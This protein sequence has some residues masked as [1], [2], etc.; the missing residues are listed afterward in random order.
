MHPPLVLRSCAH[1][2]PIAWRILFILFMTT[3]PKRNTFR[4]T[5][6][7]MLVKFHV[8]ASVFL[9]RSADCEVGALL[10]ALRL[11]DRQQQQPE[12]AAAPKLHTIMPCDT[13]KVHTNLFL[14]PTVATLIR[15]LLRSLLPTVNGQSTPMPTPM[16]VL[17][18]PSCPRHPS[19]PVVGFAAG[20]SALCFLFFCVS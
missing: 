7:Q 2:P 3:R 19:L 12:A 10:C 6:R 16:M 17:L 11:P 13:F 14:F 15:R 20:A 8:H 18:M 1:C 4:V 9:V 5:S